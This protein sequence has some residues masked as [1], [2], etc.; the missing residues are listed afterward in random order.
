MAV[1][2]RSYSRMMDQTSAEQKTGRPGAC[3]A[4]KSLTACSLAVSV[5]EC[6]HNS[7]GAHSQCLVDSITHAVRIHGELNFTV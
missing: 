4:I 6:D 3:S 7:F 1:N 5:D 2:V